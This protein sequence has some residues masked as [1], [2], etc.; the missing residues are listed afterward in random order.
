MTKHDAAA[1]LDLAALTALAEQ[2]GICSPAQVIVRLTEMI[3]AHN[4]YLDYRQRKGRTGR[5]NQTVYEE[6]LVLAQAIRFLQGLSTEEEQ[7]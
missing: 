7:S 4:A 5:Y 2:R 1:P 6:T 3:H